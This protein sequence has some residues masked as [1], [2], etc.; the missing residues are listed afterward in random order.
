MSTRRAIKK[1]ALHK[2]Y[3]GLTCKEKRKCAYYKNILRKL[4]ILFAVQTESEQRDRLLNVIRVIWIY[5]NVVLTE[6][7]LWRIPLVPLHRTIDSFSDVDIPNLF[8]FRSKIQLHRLL[9][10]LKIPPKIILPSRHTCT[11]EE[12]LLVGLIR[13]SSASRLQDFEAVFGKS[14]SWMSQLFCYFVI[15]M[16]TTYGWLLYDNLTYWQQFFPHYSECWRAKVEILSEGRLQYEPNSFKVCCS[17]DCVNQIINRPGTGPLVDGPNSERADPSGWIQRIYYNGWLADTGLKYGTV[18]A[19][20]GMTIFA[21]PAQTS[22]NNDLVWLS[23]SNINTKFE[24]VQ[25]DN[26]GDPSDLFKMYGDS[27]F[28][29]MSCLRSRY[30]GNNITP[31]ESLEN[32]VISSCRQHV[33]WHYGEVKS[34]F[35]FVDYSRKHN[36]LVSPVSQSFVTAMILRN[37]YVTLNENKTSAFFHCIPPTLESF[38]NFN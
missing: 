28:P 17:V 38:L 13:L 7:V 18:D 27:I 22:R 5:R 34:L 12:L 1:Y 37:C 10:C 29:W 3:L 35:P 26:G 16:E 2:R 23:N 33:E 20:C 14:Y 6:R 4:T 19:P 30:K 9:Q 15:W 32:K 25:L 36:L 8:R 11:G 21:S 24:A 31:I